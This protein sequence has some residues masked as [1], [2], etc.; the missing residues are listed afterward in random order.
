[1]RFKL[2]GCG[3]RLDA[4]GDLIE[5]RMILR[6]FELAEASTSRR[7][8]FVQSVPAHAKMARPQASLST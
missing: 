4:A 5:A 8:T 6:R 7:A 2:A 1:M 3:Q